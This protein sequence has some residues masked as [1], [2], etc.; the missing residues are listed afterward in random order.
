M[1]VLLGTSFDYMMEIACIQTITIL[2]KYFYIWGYHIQ[3]QP[4]EKYI[5]MVIL[6]SQLYKPTFYGSSTL[7]ATCLT[8]VMQSFGYSIFHDRDTP[9][10][11]GFL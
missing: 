8:A 4:S 9:I 11:L 5:P 10:Q 2:Y 1:T 6:L 3:V 7:L